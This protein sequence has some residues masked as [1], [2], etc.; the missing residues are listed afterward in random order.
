VPLFYKQV[1][2]LN[3]MTIG[4]IMSLN[5]LIIAFIEMILIYKIDGKRPA[6]WF[7]SYGVILTG[8]SFLIFNVGHTGIIVILSMLL[9]TFGEMFSMPFMNSFWI[10]RS[11]EQN[12]GQYA[13]L[14][15]IAY[16][17]AHILAPTLGS[18]VVQYFGFSIWWYVVGAM[19]LISSVGFGYL[20][21]RMQNSI[22]R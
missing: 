14:Y 15:T 13:A 10:S 19:C 7:I 21:K 12:R 5:G 8:C 3:E 11:S 22:I 17:A 16:S 2:H 4:L 1:I 18:R 9:I 20:N 6:L